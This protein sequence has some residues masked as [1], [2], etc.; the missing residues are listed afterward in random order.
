[1]AEATPGE[2]Q[3]G[4]PPSPTS[5]RIAALML[6]VFSLAVALAT[7]RIE[8]AFSSDPLGPRVFPYLI[9]GGLGLCSLWYLARPGEA[10]RWPSGTTL[11]QVLVLIAVTSI[12][13]ALMDRIG[14]VASAFL[15]CG[16]AAHLFGASLPLALAVGAVQA[17]FWF[18]LF[19]Y[20]LGT[21]LPAGTWLFPG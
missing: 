18:A 2:A 1:M 13:V 14:F 8:Y 11:G 7:N 4:D 3:I 17:V 20:L 19:R 9:A 15:M 12:A 5:G 10:E 21:Y 6:L 16:L